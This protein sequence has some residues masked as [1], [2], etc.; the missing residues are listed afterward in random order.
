[1]AWPLSEELQKRKPQQPK[2]QKYARIQKYK[3][4]RRSYLSWK[5]SIP[6]GVVFALILSA[7]FVNNKRDEK[8][9]REYE[10]FLLP[11]NDAD[12][13]SFCS[14]D[15]GP[16]FMR[17]SKNALKVFIGRNEA[18]ASR[19]PYVVLR[20]RK[21]D[22]MIVDR[23]LTGKLALSVDIL[24]T[25]GKVIVTF[26]KGHFTVVQA[27]ILDMKRPDKS[28]LI[29]RDHYKNEV[30]N[31]RFLN[32]RSVQF[33]GLLRYPEFRA[34]VIPKSSE[35]SGMCAGENAGARHLALAVVAAADRGGHG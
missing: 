1:V 6:L 29:G 18:F 15:Q 13:P 23:D 5:F 20:V 4:D 2:K 7:T 34:I 25:E 3:R 32:K 19:F 10:G 17:I 16:E 33:S 12:I 28:T 35:I 21:K 27:N 31:V 24:D 11:A 8:F 26:E 22:R 14:E 30:L 9:L